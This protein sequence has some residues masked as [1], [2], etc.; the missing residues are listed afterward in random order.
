M[1]MALDFETALQEL[2]QEDTPL[3]SHSLAMLSATTRAE[4]EAFCSWWQSISE[5]RQ[6]E[7][8]ARMVDLAEESFE[9]DYMA[10]FRHCLTSSDPVVRRYAIEGLWEDESANL[11]A[12]L[13]S[14]LARDPDVDV[15]AAAA[16]S[17][18]R[19]IFAAECE[20]LD[21]QHETKIRNALEHV[22]ADRKEDVA[23]VR[24]AVESIAF[25]NDNRVRRIIDRAYEHDDERMRQ[26]AVFA[27]GRSADVF[28]ADTVLLE[29]DNSSAAMRYE[30]VRACGEL[31]LKRAVEP[32]IK[33]LQDPDR[34]VQEM[35][36]WSLG[37]IGGK[38]A[39]TILDALAASDDELLSSA[40]F[41]A[42]DELE[43]S[44][45]PLDLIVHEL[46][47]TDSERGELLA[48][49][50]EGDE[51]ESFEDEA[52]STDEDEWADEFIDV[53]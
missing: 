2:A 33:L 52:D 38:R 16:S 44:V 21:E 15:R 6:R 31:Q 24:R 8:I 27:M 14:M 37:Q 23:V 43:F 1:D 18:G 12:P 48:E 34:E 39:K 17:L 42:I 3:S 13:T 41:D 4:T 29:L 32:I 36:V 10:L 45:R 40:A 11:V 47:G 46:D 25:I 5:Q 28:W 30:A 7:I 35:A 51:D 50:E 9:L 22:I 26:S 19:F 53:N 49:D 20:E